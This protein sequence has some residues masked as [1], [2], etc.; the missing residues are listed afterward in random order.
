MKTLGILAGM[1]PMAGAYFYQRVIANTPATRDEEHIPVLLCGI[2]QIPDRTAHLLGQGASPLPALADGVARLTAAGA[3]LIA[4]PCNTAHAYLG[5]LK[6]IARIPILDMP[7]ECLRH[8]ARDGAETVGVLSTSGARAAG[9]FSSA[10]CGVGLKDIY[11]SAESA[12]RIDGLIYRQKQGETLTAE[13]Y[14]PYVHELYDRG[15]EAIVLGCT[16][17]SVA[18]SGCRLQGI[19]DALEA[20]A[21]LAVNSCLETEREEGA[22]EVLTATAG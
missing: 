12:A 13:S 21:L 11:P 15:A 3:R 19:Y 20:L 1:G 10:A 8:I 17:I 18:F 4:M 6:K 14:A 5:T 7:Q 22:D 9:V 16:E 2:P